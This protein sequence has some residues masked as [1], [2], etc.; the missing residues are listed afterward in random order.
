MLSVWFISVDHCV[1]LNLFLYPLVPSIPRKPVSTG[2]IER[3]TLYLIL[4]LPHYDD[5][6][7]LGSRRK[8]P[9][10]AL[11][12]F[13]ACLGVCID[14]VGR[15]EFPPPPSTT[16]WG[17]PFNILFIGEKTATFGMIREEQSRFLAAD[18]NI[19]TS[20]LLFINIDF[21]S[22]L[23]CFDLSNEDLLYTLWHQIYSQ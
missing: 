19:L 20:T 4:Q 12:V 1:T 7:I 2:C 9:P 14:I 17:L 13:L 5:P 22:V 15:G 16:I 3:T 8:Y 21:I 11:A 18:W 6:H 23:H 10:H